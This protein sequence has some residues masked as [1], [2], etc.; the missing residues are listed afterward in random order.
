MKPLGRTDSM[1]CYQTDRDAP[2]RILDLRA[3]TSNLLEV[4]RLARHGASVLQI[5]LAHSRPA[6]RRP[7]NLSH[8]VRRGAA[9]LPTSW[10]PFLG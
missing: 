6:K 1:L 10:T 9:C 7:W 2:D 4:I 3:S 8:R 5:R